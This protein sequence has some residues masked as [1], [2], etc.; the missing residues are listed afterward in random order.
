MEPF[1]PARDSRND[2]TNTR[3]QCIHIAFTMAR[4]S[5]ACNTEWDFILPVYHV[6]PYQFEPL[7]NLNDEVEESEGSDSDSS[8]ESEEEKVIEARPLN[9]W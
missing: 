2:V 8:R 6:K 1:S 4:D 9:E 5:G 7:A 3:P